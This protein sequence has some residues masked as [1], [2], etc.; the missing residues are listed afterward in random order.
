MAVGSLENFSDMRFVGY[1]RVMIVLQLNCFNA[2]IKIKR[3]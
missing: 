3:N 2:P 1:C